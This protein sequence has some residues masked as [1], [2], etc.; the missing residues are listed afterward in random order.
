[1]FRDHRLLAAFSLGYYVSLLGFAAWDGRPQAP[2]YALFMALAMMLVTFVNARVGFSTGVLWALSIWGLAHMA[3]GLVQVDGEVLY[4]SQLIPVV[5]RYDQA[6]HAFGFG[7]A[8]LACWQPLRRWVG[9][10]VTPGTGLAVLIA[11]C[12]MGVGA[13]NEMIEFLITRVQ[14]ESNVGGFVNTGWDL[15]FNALGC[16]V[17]AGF[18]TRRR[19]IDEV[20]EVSPE[21]P[22]WR[23]RS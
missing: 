23:Q 15:V 1:M 21:A 20:V 19:R 22:L 13:V 6:V 10:T 12:G 2:F 16:V 8:T 3:G 7:A 14:P 5:L 9:A 18:L 4:G 11:L 17:A